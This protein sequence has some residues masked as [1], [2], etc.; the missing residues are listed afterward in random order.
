[1]TV[2]AHEMGHVLGLPDDPAADPVTGNVMADHLPLGVRRINLEGLLPEAPAAP[3]AL[4][5]PA[6][7]AGRPEG[8]AAGALPVGAPRPGETA[9]APF[10]LNSSAG[11]PT[12]PG[13][14][15]SYP[16]GPAVSANLA[17]ALTAVPVTGP[18]SAPAGPGDKV[19]GAPGS[20]TTGP[21][22]PFLRGALASG[23]PALLEPRVR[24]ADHRGLDHLFAELGRPPDDHFRSDW[25]L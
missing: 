19:P 15:G 13:G 16:P 11:A 2:L 18:S 24:V 7:L 3:A 17:A 20:V 12:G 8:P 6:A 21:P 5:L 25:W 14:L 10:A 22:D 1:L 9:L 23:A 4:G